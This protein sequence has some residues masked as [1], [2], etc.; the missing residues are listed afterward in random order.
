MFAV[1]VKG[2]LALAI[3]IPS[4]GRMSTFKQ[5][6]NNLPLTF[7][8]NGD[9]EISYVD[10]G[11]DDSSMRNDQVDNAI[12][13]S[14][15]PSSYE[16][17]ISLSLPFAGFRLMK[18]LPEDYFSMEERS[19]NQTI[20]NAYENRTTTTYNSDFFS[21]SF[22]FFI[23]SSS[24]ATSMKIA[25]E[26]SNSAGVFIS[27]GLDVSDLEAAQPKQR[28]PQQSNARMDGSHIHWKYH[29][30]MFIYPPPQSSGAIS[31]DVCRRKYNL[32]KT[33]C[34]YVD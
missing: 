26:I 17:N 21:V 22:D 18:I 32:F 6:F 29:E 33:T 25:T 5:R 30:F 8:Y 3:L 15:A 13:V 28:K 1:F 20:Y 4:S 24:T 2:V 9:C 27:H 19:T 11:A 14:L 34:I 31:D 23:P 7:S 12:I 10:V 16:C